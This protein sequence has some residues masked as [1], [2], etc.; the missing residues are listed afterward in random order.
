M[1]TCR[2][3][4]NQFQNKKRAIIFGKSLMDSVELYGNNCIV[5]VYAFPPK[6]IYSLKKYNVYIQ[7]LTNNRSIFQMAFLNMCKIM[8]YSKKHEFNFFV[9]SARLLTSELISFCQNEPFTTAGCRNNVKC[10]W[11]CCLPLV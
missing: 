10:C 8:L 9:L 4:L 11:N 7:V 6:Y 5:A 2:S 1:L 3:T